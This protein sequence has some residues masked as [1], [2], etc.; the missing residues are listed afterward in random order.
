MEMMC[1]IYNGVKYEDCGKLVIMRSGSNPPHMMKNDS[2]VDA[3]ADYYTKGDGLIIIE[4]R[5]NQESNN[6]AIMV[7]SHARKT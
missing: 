4:N 5:D 1:L 6:T 2:I 7:W 3:I